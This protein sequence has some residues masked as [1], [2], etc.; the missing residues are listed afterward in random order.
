MARDGDDETRVTE[1]CK[2]F[3]TRPL[4]TLKH[5]MCLPRHIYHAKTL[6]SAKRCIAPTSMRRRRVFSTASTAVI[7]ILPRVHARLS[8]CWCR[9]CRMHLA[10]DE[11]DRD[12]GSQAHIVNEGIGP[13]LPTP[14]RLH[15]SNHNG[16]S[17]SLSAQRISPPGTS[18]AQ[19]KRPPRELTRKGNDCHIVGC[20]RSGTQILVQRRNVIAKQEAR[21]AKPLARAHGHHHPK[22][23]VS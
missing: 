3:Q 21:H 15:L 20:Q 13:P 16:S 6:N 19:R 23:T 9:G 8:R 22:R 4:H 5:V 18:I 14:R 1:S 17:Q 11:V 10:P 7:A 2:D 12:T